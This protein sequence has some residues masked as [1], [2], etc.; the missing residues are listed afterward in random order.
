MNIINFFFYNPHREICRLHSFAKEILQKKL[1]NKSWLYWSEIHKLNVVL[2]FWHIYICHLNLAE[3]Q[4]PYK[5]LSSN[6]IF[7][8]NVLHFDKKKD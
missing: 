7:F 4:I 2:N 3:N 1:Q 8:Q 5:Y 6:S